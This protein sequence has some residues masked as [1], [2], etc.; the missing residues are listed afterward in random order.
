MRLCCYCFLLTC[1]LCFPQSIVHSLAFT[2]IH[3]VLS[4]CVL[5]LFCLLLVVQL[6]HETFTFSPMFPLLCAI[7][8][9]FW[10]DLLLPWCKHFLTLVQP[11]AYYQSSS[12]ILLYNQLLVLPIASMRWRSYL[13]ISVVSYNVLFLSIYCLCQPPMVFGFL[14]PIGCG[15]F[16][17]VVVVVSKKKK[18]FWGLFVI[19]G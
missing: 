14:A 10:C 3:L 15:F 6:A 9:S 12:C 11:L 16:V 1:F 17:V 5:I 13:A 8:F 7:T 4:I 2:S 19:F 18:P